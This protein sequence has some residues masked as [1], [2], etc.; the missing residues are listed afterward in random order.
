MFAGFVISTILALAPGDSKLGA[1]DELAWRELM[2][3]A[4][5]TPNAKEHPDAAAK[6]DAFSID[7]LITAS[8]K[9]PIYSRA[10][11]KPR[12]IDGKTEEFE[13]FGDTISGYSFTVDGHVYRYAVNLPRK[14]DPK[15]S[16]PLLLDPGHGS[17]SDD[18]TSIKAGMLDFYRGMADRSGGKDWIV[19]R[20]EIIEQIGGGGIFEDKPEDE[21]VAVFDDFFRDLLS[22]F[23]VDLS[24]IRVAGISQTGFWSWYLAAARPGRFAGLAPAGAVTWQVE[25]TLENLRNLAIYVAHGSVDKICPVE[26]PRNIV[27]RLAQV[28][29]TVEYAEIQGAGHDVAVFGKIEDGLEFLSKHKRDPYPKEVSKAVAN[30]DEG[31]WAYWLRV[32]ELERED[33]GQAKKKRPAMGGIDGRIVGQEIQLYSEGVERITLCLAS[34]MLDLSSEVTVIW[35]G[36][37][38]Y[39]GKLQPSA[40]TLLELVAIKSDWRGTFEAKLELSAP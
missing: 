20:T 28:G 25:P 38:V 29:A 6:F 3:A 35:N 21:V 8:R 22:R 23:H 5:A 2:T 14:Y 16:W 27:R 4:L 24:E 11:T 18:K 32:N 13:E 7:D 9:G 31:G 36:K 17:A 40:A 10:S 26:Q 37:A 33:E 15:K 19:V 1:A 39:K 34:E 30:L 12:T